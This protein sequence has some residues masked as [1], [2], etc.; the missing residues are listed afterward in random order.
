MTTPL[1]E[2]RAITKTFPGVRA[3]SDVSLEVMP[4]EIHG[5]V[6]KNGAGK[7]TLV[8]V[9]TGLLRPD[10]GEIYIEGRPLKSFDRRATLEAGIGLV[11]QQV[12]LIPYLTVAENIFCGKLPTDR[13]GNV[14]WPEVYRRAQEILDALNVP[15]N[16]RAAAGNLKVAEQ[17]MVAI[18]QAM[19]SDMKL[20]ILDEPTAALP[21]DDA[22]VMFKFIRELKARG[23]AFIYISHHLNEVFAVCDRVTVLRDGQ[24]VGTYPVSELDM[25][26]LVQLISGSNVESYRRRPAVHSDKPILE[27]KNLCLPGV[28]YDVNLSVHAGE[29]VG[30]AGLQGSGA[31]EVLRALYGLERVSSGEIWVEGQRVTV[32]DPSTALAKGIAWVT[33]DRRRFGLIGIRPVKEN[34][35]LS[36]LHRLTDRLGFLPPSSEVALARRYVE[37]LNI[38][39]PSLDQPVEFLS[40]GN[41]QKVLFARVAAVKP[42]ILLLDQPTQGVDVQ[43][44]AEIFRIIDMMSREGIGVVLYSSEINELLDNCDRILVF[45]EGRIRAEIPTGTPQATESHILLLAEGG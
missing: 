37:E 26:T 40:G 39:T 8:N 9:L 18:A 15:V 31:A 38:I 10:R 44:K 41:Q 23:V 24:Y 21:R 4:G 12:R 34:I 32:T 11:P 45:R 33:D 1:V 35:A 19:A 42:R 27:V 22:E 2:L 16:A 43:A 36:V 30:L 17:K 25:P 13:L 29:V 7:S 14:N 20:I 5:L 28:F 3:L 6:G